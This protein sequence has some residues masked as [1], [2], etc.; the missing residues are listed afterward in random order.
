MK[1]QAIIEQTDSHFTILLEQNGDTIKVEQT[2]AS[3]SDC[4]SYISEQDWQV[5][6]QAP[7]S[8]HIPTQFMKP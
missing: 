3:Y 6:R 8:L 7:S 2:F 5:A 1:P 4:L